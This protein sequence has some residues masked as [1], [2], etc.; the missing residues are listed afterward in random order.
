MRPNIAWWLAAPPLAVVLF[1]AGGIAAQAAVVAA[2]VA[3][4]LG[5]LWPARQSPLARLTALL[6]FAALG[7]LALLLVLDQFDYSYV[8]RASHTA[9]PTLYKLANI[10]GGDEGTLLLL[11]ALISLAAVRLGGAPGWA[12]PGALALTA[13][14]AAGAVIWSPFAALAPELAT[15]QGQGMNAHLVRVWML[16]HPPLVF[17]AFAFF[18]APYAAA[19]EALARGGGAWATIAARWTRYGWLTLT[20]GLVS[21]MWW[22]YEDFTFGQFW[23]WDPVQTSVFMVWALASAHLHTLRR[24][25]DDGAYG[26]LHPLLGLATALAALVALVVTRDPTLASS[27][28]YVGDTSFPWLLILAV[29]LFVMTV[30]ALMASYRR[31]LIRPRRTEA[32]ALI[33]IATAALCACAV[34]AA[35]SI[36]EAYW[37]VAQEIP[38]PDRFKPFF[39]FLAR[40]SSSAEADRLAVLFDQWD[41]DGHRLNA[42]LAPVGIVIGLAGGHNFAPWHDR[43]LR[44]A[45]TAAISTLALLSAYVWHPTGYF[46]TGKG[47]TTASTTAMFPWLDAMAV[48]MAYLGL[49]AL[50][51]GVSAVIR[52]GRRRAVGRYYLPVGALHLGVVVALLSATA[53]TVF[54]VYNWRNL[55]YPEDFAAPVKFPSGYEVTVALDYETLSRAGLRGDGDA[56]GFHAVAEVAWSLRRDGEEV[57]GERGQTVYRDARPAASG[58]L[59]PVRL[60]CEILDYRYARTVSGARQMIDP[61]L[62]RGLWRD[63]QIWL[64]AIKYEAGEGPLDA[65]RAPSTVPVVLKIFPMMSW[66]WLGLALT[67]AAA[68]TAMG[69]EIAR[70]GTR[71]PSRPPPTTGT[72]R[73]A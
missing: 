50:A 43:R 7:D 9:L 8:W 15:E 51:W 62:H 22:A 21:G 67:L 4:A 40:W 66:M 34:V 53:A 71:R 2:V 41:V 25:R 52:H 46:F 44:W 11:A 5:A 30:A 16:L 72:D 37:A 63:V 56:P 27:H 60:M 49:A 68:A 3:G 54:D 28:R 31:R 61:F 73:S 58:S 1:A 12:A 70:A 47:M 29:A 55:S 45:M 23:H 35:G 57:Q 38:R 33:L 18:L 10:W 64:P 14:L 65:L 59:G 48:A 24:Y 6:L 32:A 39:E 20:V 17:V 19:L 36:A 69:F 13:A 42:M 26:R